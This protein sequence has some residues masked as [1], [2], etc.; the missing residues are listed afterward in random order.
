MTPILIDFT[1]DTANFRLSDVADGVPFDMNGDGST[2][3][4]AWTL[5]TQRVGFL[6]LDRNHDGQINNG[7]ELF[8]NA[9]LLADGARARN[10]FEALKDLDENG[11]GVVDSRDSQFNNLRI[12]FDLNHDGISQTHELFTMADLEITTLS[13]TYKVDRR[14]DQNGNQYR[15]EG[16]AVIGGRKHRVFDV[17][18]AITN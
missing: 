15:Y 4:T 13:T 11:D 7:R 10:G 1:S 8:G 12:W 16:S 9:T 6:V 14:V 17:V 18:L 3:R 2:E 5:A